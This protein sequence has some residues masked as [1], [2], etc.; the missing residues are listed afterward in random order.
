[1]PRTITI[2]ID[3]NVDMSIDAEGF[4][5]QAC[6]ETTD[7][8]EALLRQAGFHTELKDREEKPEM[9]IQ[10]HRVLGGLTGAH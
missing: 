1:M 6:K 4:Q 2:T 7:K 5:G 3:E 10:Q 8:L 9:A